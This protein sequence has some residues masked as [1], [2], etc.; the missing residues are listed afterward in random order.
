M[1]D[2]EEGEEEGGEEGGRE[3]GRAVMVE[4]DYRAELEKLR[5]TL[6][7]KVLGVM[8][9]LKT[10][11]REGFDWYVYLGGSE[12]RREGGRE[13]GWDGQ[14]VIRSPFVPLLPSLPPSLRP[15]VPPQ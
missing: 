13:G 1:Q 5:R 9:G 7:G 14:T 8:E 12:G 3:R 2:E 6:A 15:S 4:M 10:G 11:G